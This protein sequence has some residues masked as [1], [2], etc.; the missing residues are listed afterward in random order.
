MEW[1]RG[2]SNKAAHSINNS[3]LQGAPIIQPYNT[4]NYIIQYHGRVIQEAS[5]AVDHLSHGCEGDTL[6]ELHLF[7]C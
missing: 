4:D 6:T 5:S 2:S 7:H 1:S 3:T